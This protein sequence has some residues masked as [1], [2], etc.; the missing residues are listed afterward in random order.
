[1][2]KVE[3]ISF[4]DLN[5]EYTSIIN[6]MIRMFRIRQKNEETTLK[7]IEDA[8]NGIG[9]SEPFDNVEDLMV[10]LNA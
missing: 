10:A 6:D 8:D 1:M 7:V 4:D 5:N 9:L 3:A 2:T